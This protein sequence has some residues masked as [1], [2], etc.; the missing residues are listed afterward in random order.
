MSETEAGATITGRCYC[1]ARRITAA[2]P[3]D[4][5]AY[6]HCADCR[7][8]TGGPVAAFAAFAD[9][10]V[11]VTPDEGAAVSASPGVTRRFCPECGSPLTAR[12][13]YL[14]GQ[15]Y[16]AIGVLDQA[17][18]LAPSVHAHAGERLCWL[19]IDDDLDRIGG[20][21]KER[22]TAARER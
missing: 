11:T 18:A 17:D 12:Y 19:T 16:V 20:S 15:V 8:V 7:R 10:A 5:I 1:G 14:P 13:A 6:C 21:S 3:P 9:G 2:A 4:I 22:L